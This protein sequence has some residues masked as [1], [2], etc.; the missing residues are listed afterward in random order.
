MTE[1][2]LTVRVP[3]KL[4]RRGGRKLVISPEGSG[5]WAPEQAR[6]D[7]T[8]VKALARAFRWRKQLET[9]VHT[10][11]RDIAKAEQINE[12]YVFRVYRLTMLA[13]DIIEAILDGR[14]PEWL[15]LAKVME[16]FPCEWKTQRVLLFSNG[17][18]G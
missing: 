11:I 10:C 18:D 7:S 9:G 8:L 6:I 17:E 1:A 4:T 16:P 12:S 15:A 3:L 2:T 14:Q 5:P 13:P